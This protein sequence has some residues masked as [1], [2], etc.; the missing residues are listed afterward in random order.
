MGPSN[1]MVFTAIS[2]VL[3]TLPLLAAAEASGGVEVDLHKG[4]FIQIALFVFLMLVLKP[5]LFDPMLRLFEER[6]KRTDG[7]KALAREIDQKS[8]SAQATYDTEMA[9]ARS[10]ANVE[11]D[12]LRAE[13]LRA[14]NEILSRV[15]VEATTTIEE[16]R[17]KTLI[18]ADA[19][20]A[21]LKSQSA[22]LARA[23]ASRVLGREVH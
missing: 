12:K 17:K 21:E 6:E 16:G 2:E 8:A 11:R 18:E 3:V 13:G 9:K 22:E 19:A 1:T 5:L 15:R 7:A 23:V 14:E 10:I 4:L 20:R